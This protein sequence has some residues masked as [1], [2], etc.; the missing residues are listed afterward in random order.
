MKF[1]FKL[2]TISNRFMIVSFFPLCPCRFHQAEAD[3]SKAI[4]L[5]K[6]VIRVGN[7]SAVI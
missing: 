7:F 3:C 6:K 4:D 1:P 5:D 2:L